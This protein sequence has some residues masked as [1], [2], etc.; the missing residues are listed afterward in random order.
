[1]DP[2]ATSAT[3]AWVSR[4]RGARGVVRGDLVRLRLQQC[5]GGH[6]TPSLLDR[7]ATQE[8]NVGPLLRFA[9]GRK[10]WVE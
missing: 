1:M 2:W 10:D 6:R 9:R 8:L 7:H 3:P 5:E 4:A